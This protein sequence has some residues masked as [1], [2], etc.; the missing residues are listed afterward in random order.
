MG[1]VEKLT[2]AILA[3]HNGVFKV[4]TAIANLVETSSSLA[5]II[6]KNGTFEMQS[7]Q[8]SSVDSAKDDVAGT[9][10]APFR[11]IG[12]NVEHTGS[13]PGWAPN[14]KSEILELME[15]KYTA[16]FGEKPKVTAI[17]AGLEC[18]LLGK[19]YP[20]VDMISFGP[21]IRNPHSPDEKCNIPSVVKFWGFLIDI[22]K[23]APAK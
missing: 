21:T 7:L 8:R 16:S 6:I 20:N 18:G 13:Y 17:H 4:S 14:P 10:A 11:L 2:N 12:A 9:V 15:S 3:V 22:L 1:D 5:R 19:K 23:D